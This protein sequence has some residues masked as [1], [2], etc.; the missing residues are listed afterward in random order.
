MPKRKFKLTSIQFK[1][2][3]LSVHCFMFCSAVHTFCFNVFVLFCCSNNNF[4]F[5]VFS[6]KPLWDIIDDRWDKQMH[7]PLHAAGYYLNPK[8]HY[9]ADFKADFEVKRGLYDCLERMIGDVQEISKI[10]AQLEAFKTR[11]KFVGSPIAMAAL[12]TKTPA[13]WWE[14]YGDEHP[15]LQK[16]AIRVLSLTC[17]SSGCERNWSGFEMVSF[18]KILF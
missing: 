18:L 15:E 1:E 2:G 9:G 5:Y 14:S 7:M 6:Y 11:A 16:F 3:S 12:G 13:Q 10:D 4:C 17:S 8:L